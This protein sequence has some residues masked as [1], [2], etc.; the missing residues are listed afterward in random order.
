[1]VSSVTP[2]RAAKKCTPQQLTIT[3]LT[4]IIVKTECYEDKIKMRI[5]TLQPTMTSELAFT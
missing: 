4:K 1:M 2:L 5:T 3:A